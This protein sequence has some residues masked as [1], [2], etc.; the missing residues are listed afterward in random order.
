MIALIRAAVLALLLSLLAPWVTSTAGAATTVPTQVAYT[1]DAAGTPSPRAASH[2]DR[3]PPATSYDDAVQGS[4]IPRNLS[5]STTAEV[6]NHGV[7]G[8]LAESPFTSWTRD[9]AIAQRFAGDDGVIL[10]LPTGRP[11][12][13]SSWKFEWSPDV[14]FEDEVLVRGP[15]YGAWRI[16]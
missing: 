11:P 10:R 6:H 15:V 16:Q 5:G 4:V 12:A 7:V 3:G 9:P 14:W 2:V 8:D 13:G 1:Y